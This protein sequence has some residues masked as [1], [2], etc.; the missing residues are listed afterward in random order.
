MSRLIGSVVSLRNLSLLKFQTSIF[1]TVQ[2]M[3]VILMVSWLGSL[4]ELQLM[5][6]GCFIATEMRG[7]SHFSPSLH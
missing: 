6:G 1:G 2:Q 3:E 4:A 5:F 7:I